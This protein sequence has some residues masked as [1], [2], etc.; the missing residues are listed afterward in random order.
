MPTKG[1][2]E[3]K[4]FGVSETKERMGVAPD[5]IPDLKA[6]MGDSSDNYPGVAGIGPKTAVGLINRFG[7]VKA[8]YDQGERGDWGDVG[9]GIKVKLQL[10][11]ESAF[12]SQDLA[13]IRRDAPVEADFDKMRVVTL[14][15][16][17]SRGMLEEFNFQSLVKRLTGEISQK[18]EKVEKPVKK[19]KK[20]ELSEN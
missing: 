15:T 17:Q 9:E 7:T 19:K 11:K 3:G 5:Q 12:L 8:L 6:L 18:K 4:L 2:S 10:G 13:T 16:P 14:D 1:L 20:Q